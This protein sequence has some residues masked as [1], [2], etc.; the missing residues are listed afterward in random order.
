M[1]KSKSSGLT[2]CFLVF[3]LALLFLASPQLASAGVP[4]G[5]P[6]TAYAWSVYENGIKEGPVTIA[7]PQGDI[8]LIK[9][10]SS[11]DLMAGGD[12]V[13]STWYTVADDGRLF[14]VD[15]ATGNYTVIGDTGITD[16]TGFT[17]DITTETAYVSWVSAGLDESKLYTIDLATASITEVGVITSGG[18]I[19]IAANKEGDLYGLDIMDDKLYRIDKDTGAGTAI[20]DI[21]FNANFAQD[22]AFDRK[23]GTLYGT[24]FDYDNY[25]GGLYRF[26]LGTG[27]AALLK[28]FDTE[29][30]LT[31]LAI[32]YAD[33]KYTVSAE[34]SPPA[35]GNV[36][37]EG[38]YNGGTMVTL[39]ADAAAGYQ[40]VNWTEDG[41]VVSTEQ[42][43][44]FAL[45]NDCHLVA[46]FEKTAVKGTSSDPVS[47]DLSEEEA[48]AKPK[49]ELPATGAQGY[50]F[51]LLGFGL[52]L[53]AGGFICLRLKKQS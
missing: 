46:N 24:L 48:T 30:E 41:V 23:S 3:L 36:T 32:P 50:L 51:I 17:Y 33:E 39:S 25:S 34:A 40:F 12:F 7:I 27:A 47:P 28:E 11:V 18:I 45:F 38:E 5:E 1:F 8:N 44:R 53:T 22:I 43:Y 26:N 52:L 49:K 6:F 16:L 31:A 14:T 37:G 4:V 35:G 42:S 10:D 2:S 15:C 13:G 20:G 29:V 9:E 19:G 21:G